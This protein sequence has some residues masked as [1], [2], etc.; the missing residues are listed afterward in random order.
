MKYFKSPADIATELGTHLRALRLRRNLDQQALAAQAGVALNAVKNLES[1][2]G[3]SVRSLLHVLRA[4][5]REDWI[6]AL[7][8][9]V[10]ISPLQVLKRRPVR[11]RATRSTPTPTRKM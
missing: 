7:A 8:P 11:Q 4:L 10:S 9:Q 1:G 2:R 3:A 5:D 6:Q